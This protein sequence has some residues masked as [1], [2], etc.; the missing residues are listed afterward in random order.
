M[1]RII[2]VGGNFAGLTSA[3]E[4][5]RKLSH[6]HEIIMISKS[7]N[8]L[9]TP[10]LIW[11]PFGKRELKDIA[12]PLRPLAIKA[13]IQF[14]CT[15]VMEILAEDKVV[16]CMDKDFEYDYLII[17]TG[18]EWI[19]DQVAG[20]GLNSNVSFIV[21]PETA[22]ETRKRWLEFIMDPGPVVIGAAQGSQCTGP[23]YEFLFN[24]E[25]RCRDLGIRKQVDITFITPEPFLGHLGIGGITG[26]NF[27]LKKLLPMFRINYI[28]NAEI[29]KVSNEDIS[30]KS[31][32][33]IPYKFSMI[34]PIFKGAKV[35][36]DSTGLGTADAFIPVNNT[37]QHKKY[38]SIFGVGV[39]SDLPIKFRTP[40]PIGV[41]KTGYAADE[42][43][44][45][46][47][48]NIVRMIN[49]NNKLEVKPMVNI[50]DLCIMDAGDKEI[51]SI[52][53]NLL[54]PRSFSIVLPNPFYDISKLMFEKYYLWKVRHG[55]SRL[56]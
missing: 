34:M 52:A 2:V 30:L 16:R 29:Q 33:S 6:D 32:P 5:S 48:E 39:A 54:K 26:S 38:P 17:A 15:E 45:T 37:Y 18:P 22:L 24:F 40:V 50:P 20:L 7:A 1:A 12:V 9:F 25:K 49:G 51:L 35:V 10:S 31:G 11:I 46:A 55:Y 28:T 4:L 8:F 42:S 3:L 27:I 43:A 41:P 21:T 14:I 19:F 53:D 13:R 47:T 56:P 36:R 44:K 23:A